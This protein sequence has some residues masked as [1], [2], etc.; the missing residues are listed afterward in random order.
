MGSDFSYLIA[1]K[2]G[3]ILLLGK[4]FLFITLPINSAFLAMQK[5]RIM[6]L[7]SVAETGILTILLLYFATS[8][9]LGIVGASLAVLF[10]YT[11][12][13]L[14]VI[15][16]LISRELSLPFNDIIKPWLRPLL[17]SFMGWAMLS[18]AYT[19]MIQEVQSALAFILCVVL[20][21][22][23]SLISVPFLVGQQE[24]TLL[25]TIVPKKYMLLFNWPSLLSRRRPA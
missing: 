22:I 9:N 19:V 17:L 14:I 23:F 4:M 13:R 6:S 1:Y 7:V 5:P 8:T 21:T 20:Y 16:F 10:S 15:P 12:T 24:R 18:S 2:V 11:P 3:A 25:E